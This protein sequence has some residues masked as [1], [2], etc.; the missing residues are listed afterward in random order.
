MNDYSYDGTS[1]NDLQNKSTGNG[2]DMRNTRD[3][4]DTRD[5]INNQQ[6]SQQQYDLHQQQYREQQ[7]QYHQQM[8]QQQEKHQQN[9][10][11]NQKEH[12]DID[13]LAKDISNNLNEKELF[14]GETEDKEDDNFTLSIPSNL[15]DPLL[16]LIIFVILSQSS[17]RQLFGKYISYINPDEE[18]VVSLMGIVIY[19]IILVAIYMLIKKLL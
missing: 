11:D 15:K 4:R 8:E 3:T 18:G 7:Q 14:D 6:M 13:E 17:V 2:R 1:I 19:G 10:V 16:L 12:F 9:E 5:T